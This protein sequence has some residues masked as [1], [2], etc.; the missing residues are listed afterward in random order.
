MN[1]F[2]KDIFVSRGHIFS[3]NVGFKRK[4][5][6]VSARNMEEYQAST[7]ANLAINIKV[8]GGAGGAG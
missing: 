2:E 5:V 8:E 6:D 3:D 4:Q 1:V 7:V